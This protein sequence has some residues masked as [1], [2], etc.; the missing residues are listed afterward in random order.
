MGV[1]SYR[2]PNVLL[3]LTDQERYD[4]TS[5]DG[6]PV[7]T[8]ALD[9]LRH[10]GMHFERAYT[11]IS[12]CSSARASLLTGLYPH[13]HGTMNNCHG[14]DAIQ[15]NLPRDNATFSKLLAHNGY[16]NSYIGKWHVGQTQTPADF[17]F[18]YLGGGDG[19]HDAADPKFEAYQRRLGVDP[20]A[21]NL[22][23]AIYTDHENASERTLV[24]A[25]TILPKEALRPYYLADKTIEQLERYAH[26]GERFFH[27]IDFEGPH[28]PY[29]VPEPYASMYDP[30]DIDPWPSFEE[31]FE[32]KPRAHKEFLSYRGVAGFEWETWA[33]AIAKYFGYVSFLDDQIGRIL[34]ALDGLELTDEMVT[35]HTADH[36]DF[37]GSHRQ[38]NKGA[39]MYE[40]TYHVPLSI[41]WPGVV[42][43]ESTCEEFVQLLDLMPTFLD[44]AGIAPPAGIDGRSILPLLHGRVPAGWP[45]SVFAE[46]HGEEFGLNSQRMVR[47]KTHKYV[48]NAPDTNELYD[49]TADPHEL[50]NRIDRPDAAAVRE[51][52][53]ANLT[54]WMRRTDDPLAKWAPRTFAG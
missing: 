13:N 27:R 14:S 40:E 45:Q 8:P 44:L 35:I 12:I 29:V 30:D 47:T 31:T 9:R 49:L 33:K 23:N 48:Y 38:F 22:D 36:G 41:R 37:T 1:Q 6:V 46:Y 43:P 24:A 18:E 42:D 28:H 53:E 51:D 16:T 10:E 52:L 15:K 7:E 39:L 34:E 5:P 20:N 54:N 19:Y 21:E 26:S 17:G 32:G 4:V 11:P 50:T 3:L 2:K 25:E